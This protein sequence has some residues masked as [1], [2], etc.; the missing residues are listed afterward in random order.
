MTNGSRPAVGRAVLGGA[1]AG[2]VAS[3]LMGMFAMIAAATYQGTGFFTPMYHIASTFISGDAMKTSMDRAMH[4][5]DFYFAAGPALLGAIVHMMWGAMLGAIFGV[6]AWWLRL[7]GAAAPVAGVVYGLAVM[8]VDSLIVL[9]IA[10]SVFGGGT[11]ISDMPQIVG[12]GTFTIE[13]AIFGL[14]VG[15]WPALRPQD[16]SAPAERPGPVAAE[17]RPRAA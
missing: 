10:A 2:L 1:I 11:P 13:H 15:L 16:V 8:I 17:A 3:V 6:L 5:S 7:R 4:G 12:W 9:P 14:V